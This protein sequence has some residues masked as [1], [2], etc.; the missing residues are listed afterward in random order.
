MPVFQSFRGTVTAIDDFWTGLGG[1][2]GCTKLMTVRDQ[3]RRIVNFVVTPDTYFV[4]HARVSVGDTVTGFYDMTAP[5]PAIY[6]AQLRA[7]VMAKAHRGQN[8]KVDFFN[9]R[10][11]SRDGSLQLNITPSTQIL[12]RN[13]QPFTG[14]PGN[15]DLIVVYGAS[16]RSIPAKT[17]PD[18]IIVMC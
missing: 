14:N 2:P 5:T 7:I 15:R 10:L 17:V 18:K 4:D 1:S 11:I 13:G 16:T 12:L 9:D 8:V 3:N 6:P